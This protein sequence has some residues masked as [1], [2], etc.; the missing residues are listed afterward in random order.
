M[1][2]W[3][4]ELPYGG[5]DPQGGVPSSMLF[6]RP[7]ASVRVDPMSVPQAMSGDI[8]GMLHPRL[9]GPPWE[10]AMIRL[11]SVAFVLAVAA[12]AQAMSPVPLHQPDGMITQVRE[13]CGAGRVRVKGVCVARTTIRQTRRKCVAY[14]DGFCVQYD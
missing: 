3:L 4:N 8:S 1:R 5:R 9:G 7:G 6:A 10:E 13:A 11:I 14:S 2:Y 12:S